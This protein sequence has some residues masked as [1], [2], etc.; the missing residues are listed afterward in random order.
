MALMFMIEAISVKNIRLHVPM[1]IILFISFFYILTIS[2][3][4]H[5]EEYQHLFRVFQIIILAF[6][7]VNIISHTRNITP[8]VMGTIIGTLI[9]NYQVWL[10]LGKT[11][12]IDST[13]GSRMASDFINSNL[14][15]MMLCAGVLINIY[16]LLSIKYSKVKKEKLETVGLKFFFILMTFFY[17]Y[18]I[19][20]LTGS[21]KGSLALLIIF[22]LYG[23][24]SWKNSSIFIR[25][26]YSFSLLIVLSNAANFIKDTI[27]FTRLEK[28]LIMFS[29]NSIKA[30][31]RTQMMHDAIALWS[32]KPLLGWGINQF[33]SISGWDTYSHNNY[34]EILVNNGL[35][36]LIVYYSVFLSIIII[37]IKQYKNS[38]GNE[39]YKVFWCFI[40]II[41]LL[42]WD[43]GLV[44]YYSKLNWLIISMVMGILMISKGSKNKRETVMDTD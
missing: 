14:Y 4:L 18:L 10:F 20:T 2:T 36:G 38:V 34:V 44:S 8:I 19:I 37:I 16:C 27:A 41:V 26:L 21:K 22:T 23:V 7:I 13:E 25:I 12:I 40:V 3:V 1:P 35:I 24:Y 30:D 6:I 43:I 11:F 32:E 28:M 33:R 39:K 29:N 17:S 31:E 5:A 9:L 42:F 15:S